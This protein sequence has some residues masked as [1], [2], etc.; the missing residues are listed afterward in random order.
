MKLK[1]IA[2]SMVN[3]VNGLANSRNAQATNRIV[4]QRLD[5]TELREINKTGLYSKMC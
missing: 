5:V 1:K 4:S 3:L 2:D